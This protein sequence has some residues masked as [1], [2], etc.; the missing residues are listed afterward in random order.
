MSQNYKLKIEN[1]EQEQ[2]ELCRKYGVD[3]QRIDFNL[4][5]GFS[6]NFFSG[7]MPLNGFRHPAEGNMCGWYF[8]AGEE[9]SKADD[10]FKPMHVFHLID[11]SP[12]LLQYLALPAGWRF[13]AAGDYEDVWF[14][15]NLL[16]I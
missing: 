9:F 10:F 5:F 15:E 4:R 11:R 6:K 12:Y 7:V 1:I 8:W 16:N 14:D 3:F 13:L 2:K